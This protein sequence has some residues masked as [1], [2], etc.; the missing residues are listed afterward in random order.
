MP[1]RSTG[2]IFGGII[3]LG[4][5]GSAKAADQATE[6]PAMPSGTGAVEAT[7]ATNDCKDLG[8]TV[9][10]ATGSAELDTNGKG[11]LDG[12]ST[13]MHTKGERI[14]KLQGFADPTG[15][16]TS[17]LALSERRADAVKA[18]LVAQGVD[19]TRISAVGRGEA[20]IAAATLPADGRTV[21]FL[22]CVP[23]TKVSEAAPPPAEP[24]TP[25][26]ETPPP[27][28]VAEVPPPMPQYET[29]PGQQRGYGSPFGFGLLVG[30]GYQDFTGGNA[31]ALTSPGGGW[32][33][34]MVAGLRSYIGFEAAYVGTAA[35][36]Q[37]LNVNNNSTLISNGLEGALRLNIPI[38]RGF[39]MFEP[40]GFAGVGWS[41]YRV[42]NN[43]P[44]FT[45]FSTVSD[46][47]MTVPLGGGLAY[48]Y[49]A[50]MIDARGS[51]VPTYFNNILLTS[52]GT[53]NNLNHWGVGGHLGV[54]F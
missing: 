33:V 1:T 8:I 19:E 54:V 52:N 16:P 5:V 6:P 53:T 42:T 31:K 39:S 49:K 2:W 14:V 12:V 22:G 38:I 37:V 36:V 48:A 43:T 4:V 7:S 46:N 3:L 15:N 27:A 17:N 28:P 29:A 35:N 45:D 34:R 51:W 40:Y 20:P 10:F 47:V 26:E 11:A 32:D 23:S 50:F 30:G 24:V 18:Y 44:A 25:V 13:W 41:S 21:T 9:S